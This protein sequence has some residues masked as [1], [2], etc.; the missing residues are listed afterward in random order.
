MDFFSTRGEG[1]DVEEG[2]GVDDDRRTEDVTDTLT[3][4]DKTTPLQAPNT[5]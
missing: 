2:A 3:A 1:V 5:D 4:D